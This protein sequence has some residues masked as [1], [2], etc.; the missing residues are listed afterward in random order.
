MVHD[1][2]YWAQP[3]SKTQAD[4]LF[5]IAMKESGVSGW[6]RFWISVGLWWGGDEA[7]EENKGEKAKDWPKVIPKEYLDFDGTWSWPDFRKYL[8]DN[9]VRDPEFPQNPAYCELGNSDEIPE[10]ESQ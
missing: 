2:L 7:W 10:S 8:V 6:D 3:C 1:Y 9:H 4:N 5:T